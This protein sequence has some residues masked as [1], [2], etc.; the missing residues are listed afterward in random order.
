[1][2]L[3]KRERDETTPSFVVTSTNLLPPNS[4]THADR[5]MVS[6][7]FESVSSMTISPFLTGLPGEGTVSV[8]SRDNTISM[9]LKTE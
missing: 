9:L 7:D 2:Y 5:G 6:V 4:L 1:M 8:S 3:L